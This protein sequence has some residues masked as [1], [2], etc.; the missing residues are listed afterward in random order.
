MLSNRY[1]KQFF[2]NR[3]RYKWHEWF[4]VVRYSQI[5][6]PSAASRMLLALDDREGKARISSKYIRDRIEPT[7]N[8]WNDFLEYSPYFHNFLNKLLEIVRNDPELMQTGKDEDDLLELGRLHME[9]MSSYEEKCSF[10]PHEDGSITRKLM[11]RAKEQIFNRRDD[12]NKSGLIVGS[13]RRGPDRIRIYH[14]NPNLKKEMEEYNRRI[15]K[16]KPRK[17]K[18]VC[19]PFD[20]WPLISNHLTKESYDKQDTELARLA[21][22]LIRSLMYSVAAQ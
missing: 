6:G 15:K 19:G 4:W 11:T 22:K 13:N 8:F 10:N 12:N 5:H 14:S 18:A 1:R 2:D 3:W 21:R 9:R 20:P 17:T 16:K 7:I